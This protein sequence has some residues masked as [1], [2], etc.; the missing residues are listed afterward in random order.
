[1]KNAFC[2]SS[3][4]LAV[5]FTLPSSGVPNSMSTPADDIPSSDEPPSSPNTFF[6]FS[7]V[8]SDPTAM[9]LTLTVNANEIVNF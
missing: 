1:M 4:G 2:P 5:N 7:V 9:S 6:R 8:A 3:L